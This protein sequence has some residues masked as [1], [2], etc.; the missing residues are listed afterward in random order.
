ML[1]RFVGYN[2]ISV[3]M[4]EITQYLDKFLKAVFQ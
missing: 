4:E 2:Q 1:T 3:R